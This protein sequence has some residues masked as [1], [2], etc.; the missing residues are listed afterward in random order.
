[1]GAPCCTWRNSMKHSL[2]PVLTNTFVSRG[3][4]FEVCAQ[5]QI[6]RGI[7]PLIGRV[8]TLSAYPSFGGRHIHLDAGLVWGSESSTTRC[9][10]GPAAPEK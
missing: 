7:T 5:E 2:E 6:R 9:L 3:D 10:P 1:M 4:M 8:D